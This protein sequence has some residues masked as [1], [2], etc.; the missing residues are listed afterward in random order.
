MINKALKHIGYGIKVNIRSKLKMKVY[1]RLIDFEVTELCNSHC[2]HCNIWCKE[3]K[4]DDLTLEQI[5][6]AFSDPFMKNI[7]YIIVTG[8]E[9]SV[10]K[11]IIDVYRILHKKCP[12]ATLQLSTNGI[13][14]DRVLEIVKTVLTEGIKLDVGLS[15]DGY[16]E[17]H[18]KM[19]GTPGNFS[20]VDYLIDE[21]KEL[22][23]QFP[24]Q[25][26]FCVGMTVSDK[27]VPYFKK[28]KEYVDEKGI[29]LE[30]A[31]Y[32]ESPYYEN[33]NH[34]VTMNNVIEVVKQLDDQPRKESIIR[35]IEGKSIRYNC[36]A[37]RD[38]F[39]LRSNGDVVPCLTY[40][41]KPIGNI[42]T[43][44]FTKIFTSKKAKF[45]RKNIVGKCPGCNNSW[46]WNQSNLC[47]VLPYVKY[48]LKRKF[49]K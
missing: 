25:F 4:G 22:K 6:T 44:S 48:Y 47:N 38:F 16:G 33:K 7:Q 19:R 28:L 35:E 43:E 30:Y 29:L 12:K 46:A 1:P 40:A 20:S 27:T 15:L 49:K 11:D 2:L 23:K 41:D 21:F 14:R 17:D 9:P 32:Q 5:D 10:R 42:K 45:I 13:L 36:W 8:G 24:N 39:V 26:N 31:W 3:K 18:D 37:L 34:K